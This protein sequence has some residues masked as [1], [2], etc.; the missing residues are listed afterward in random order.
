MLRKNRK[1]L[2]G[3]GDVFDV[4]GS[5]G[6]KKLFDSIVKNDEESL[7]SDWQEVGNYI[8]S[9]LNHQKNKLDEKG[10]KKLT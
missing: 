4:F 8:R 10:R 3:F 7:R 2:A 9:T 5:S 1:F 6:S